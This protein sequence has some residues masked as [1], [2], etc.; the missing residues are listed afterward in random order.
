ML[1]AGL[2]WLLA[3]GFAHA[4][5]YSASGAEPLLDG[6]EALFAA[7][8]KGDWAGAD[9]ALASMAGDLG[10]LDT[11]DDPGI[12]KLFADAV[13]AKDAGKVK[14]AFVEAASAEI[15]RRIDGAQKSF[16]DYQTAKVL[17]VK[18]QRFFAAVAA[19]LAPEAS[20]AVGDGLKRA[21]DALG[22]PGVFGVGAK[23]ADAAAF[24]AARADIFKALGAVTGSATPVPPFD[25]AGL[26]RQVIEKVIR[27]KFE[28][29]SVDAAQLAASLDQVCKAKADVK[30]ALAAFRAA[31]LSYAR[32]ESLT[33]GPLDQGT[34]PLR[35][36]FWPDPD[37]AVPGEV[38]KAIAARDQGALSKE[39]LQSQNEERRGFTALEL[40][41][42]GPEQARLAD[43]SP[44][45]PFRCGYALAIA[46]DIVGLADALAAEW[47]DP[48]GYA[49]L[50]TE[51]GPQNTG[52]TEPRDVTLTLGY[53]FF[54]GLQIVRD[55]RL[56]APLGLVAQNIPATPGVL[57]TSG[58]TVPMLVADIEGLRDLYVDGGFY[59]RLAA[60]DKANADLVK[61]DL[62]KAIAIG[63]ETSAPLAE[64]RAN[65]DM[66]RKLAGMGVPLLEA[67]EHGAATLARCAGAPLG[68]NA[69]DGD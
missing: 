1:L 54:N 2:V 55:S 30:P 20:K 38:A 69:M 48:A 64:I 15:R 9:K 21:L 3:A 66:K 16:A 8:A 17:V 13:A 18:A 63:R 62:D 27:P 28:H 65:R 68:F 57:E 44:E 26:A 46:A 36:L 29:L 11:H 58:L 42:Y 34:R 32:L 41:L 53:A 47:R 35:L 59:E 31:A 51:P 7:A 14:A 67:R 50:M 5:S 37:R 33:F 43:A 56:A 24:A 60:C 19:D 49:S 22:N 45:A 4:Y 61:S 39:G 52:F 25:H 10:Y 40:L 6:R 23:K 12:A